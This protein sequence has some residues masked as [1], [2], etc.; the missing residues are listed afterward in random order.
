MAVDLATLP[1]IADRKVGEHLRPPRFDE[2]RVG[3]E[4]APVRYVA[5]DAAIKAYCYAV[6]C[7]D[8]W[9]MRP[10]AP[11]EFR[12]AP[13]CMVLKELMWLYQTVYDRSRVRGLHQH[14]EAKFHRP[15]PAGIELIFTGR[16]TDKY[17]R[18]GKGYFIHESEARDAEGRLYVSQRNNEII[19][20][21]M[22]PVPGSQPATATARKARHWKLAQRTEAGRNARRHNAGRCSVAGT[23]RECRSRA[24]GG[25]L[26]RRGQLRKSPYEA[27]DRH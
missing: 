26:R 19:E 6:D 21:S 15:V 20:M 11:Y 27:A 18:R 16:V 3:E 22:A 7:Y 17:E 10:V 12:L 2:I 14:E 23:R 5:D 24:D 8:P 4:F 9:Y 13:S 25:V 1:D